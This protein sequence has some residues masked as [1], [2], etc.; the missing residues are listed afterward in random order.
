MP[1]NLCAPVATD[2]LVLDDVLVLHTPSTVMPREGER[3]TVTIVAF[4]VDRVR[5]M[6]RG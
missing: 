3:G 5:R 2:D 6:L 4:A 1:E